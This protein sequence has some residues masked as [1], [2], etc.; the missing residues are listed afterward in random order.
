MRTVRDLS[1][2]ELTAGRETRAEKVYAERLATRVGDCWRLLDPDGA[3]TCAGPSL[4][5]WL[6]ARC[7]GDPDGEYRI[8]CCWRTNLVVLRHSA[9][10]GRLLP[11]EAWTEWEA[12]GVAELSVDVN[13]TLHRI[14]PV[15]RAAFG[16]LLPEN[17]EE[18]L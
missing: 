10:R 17:W 14:G 5:A 7:S 1:A 13:G 18:R 16:E 3:M 8:E 4:A 12:D 11:D 15:D 2:D 6:S 9:R